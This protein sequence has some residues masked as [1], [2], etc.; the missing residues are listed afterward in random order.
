MRN[1]DDGGKPEHKR[2][3]FTSDIRKLMN[4]SKSTARRAMKEL[5][6]LGLVRLGTEKRNGGDSHYIE[7]VEKFDWLLDVPFQ[8]LIKDFDWNQ[9][10]APEEQEQQTNGSIYRM[11]QHSDQWACRHCKLTGDIHLMRKHVCNGDK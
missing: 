10:E 2:R 4:V 6:I 1:A 7:L 9:F 3:F 5:E 8:E 11:W